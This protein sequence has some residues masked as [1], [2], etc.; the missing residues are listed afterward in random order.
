MGAGNVLAKDHKRSEQKCIDI[1]RKNAVDD[2][3]AIEIGKFSLS[4]SGSL[5]IIRRE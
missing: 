3:H 1:I 5:E 2:T 4:F